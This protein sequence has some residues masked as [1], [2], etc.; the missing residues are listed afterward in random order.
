MK[1]TLTQNGKEV[2]A[3][4][5]NVLAAL[6]GTEYFWLDLDDASLDGTVTE[7][8][9]VHFKFHPLAVAAAE[10]FAVRPRF[11]EYDDFV[12]MG[13]V[14]PTRTT[15]GKPRSTVLDRYAISSPC[16]GATA[17]P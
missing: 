15:R 14:V 13:P 17:R 3:T 8:L 11:D 10:K 2:E 12:Y 16:T 6:A 9:S 5:E 1:G 4:S 7:L